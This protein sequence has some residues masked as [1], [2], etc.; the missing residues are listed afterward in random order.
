MS[1][2]PLL[3]SDISIGPANDTEYEAVYAEITASE[4]GRS[5]LRE[6]ASRSRQPDTQSLV[7]TIARLD[8]AMREN[9]PPQVPEALCRG[10][11]DLV[12]AIE[13]M[14]AV[15]TATGDSAPDDLFA[16]ERLQ[17][18]ALALRR[19]EVETALCDALEASAREVG[20]AMVR[21]NAAARAMSCAPQLRDL[22]RRVNELAALAA[23]IARP[24][25]PP[26][27]RHAS[28]EIRGDQK[29]EQF[30]DT[31]AAPA[32]GAA[33][34]H[35]SVEQ[36]ADASLQSPHVHPLLPDMQAPVAP[37][38]DPG[39]LPDL[40]I[41]PMPSP[42]FTVAQQQL[43]RTPTSKDK[44]ATEI[45][46]L[47]LPAAAA[48]A[49]SAETEA[50]IEK[51]S[52]AAAPLPQPSINKNPSVAAISRAGASDPLAAVLALS[53]EELIALFS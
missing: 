18:I 7:S 13:Q 44:T 2:N 23:V 51:K 17:D 42:L 6:Y 16:V 8:A 41:P 28:S 19:R 38:K 30:D 53:E 35:L 4:R 9:A 39:S 11:I 3:F 52:P 49:A 40:L 43:A 20:D 34:K 46:S 31:A 22:A 5:F 37:E 1:N 15:F 24:S 50:K 47:A 48:G 12:A 25:A 21:N 10:L 32:P 33:D 36:P 14:E 29:V 45:F 27:D 26:D